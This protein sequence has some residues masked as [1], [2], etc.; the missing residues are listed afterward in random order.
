MP[1]EREFFSEVRIHGYTLA[2]LRQAPASIRDRYLL[3]EF[4]EYVQIKKGLLNPYYAHYPLVEPRELI[5][6][7]EKNFS[8]Y[9]D[10]PS[11]SLV[12]FNRPLS[13]QDEIFQF[14][15]LHYPGET[16]ISR[17]RPDRTN[18]DKVL[19]HL[20]RDLRPMFRQ[21]FAFRDLTDLANY[22]EHLDF[23]LHMDRAHI[24]AKDSQGLFR[25]LGVYASFPS[26]LDTELK[27]LGHRLGKF[28]KLDS[29]TYEREREF[30]YQFLMELYGFPIAAE[31]RTSAALFARKLSRLKEQYLIK[32]LGCSDRTITSLSGLEQKKY[33]LVEKTALIAVPPSLAEANPHLRDQ[34]YYV[35][36]N[37]RVV[38]FK[39]TYLQHKYNRFNV[40]EDRALSV[41]KQ[42]I[43]HPY[44]GGRDT[45]LNILKDTKRFLKDL[46]DIVRGEYL[47]SIS[48]KRA[49]LITST[50]THEDRLKFLSAWLAKNQRR[51]GTLS[52]ETFEG[53]KKV[54][55]SYLLNREYKEAFAKH[56]ELHR[57]V[58]QKVAY[59]TQAQ[60]LQTLEKLAQED[61]VRGIGAAQRLGQAL[62]FLEEKQ[63]DL[64]YFYPDLL[65]KCLKLYNQILASPSLKK[66][67]AGEVS[68]ETPFQRRLYEMVNRGRELTAHLE[69][70]HRRIHTAAD[71]GVPFPVLPLGRRP[72]PPRP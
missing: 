55:N 49:D 57:E 61:E 43:L 11:F 27:N 59:L 5:P 53:V 64:P 54:L 3:K 60:Q 44:H 35:D 71:R 17:R 19:P 30:V 29:A 4:L 34:G 68:P 31:R 26:D 18:L 39:V 63:S 58:V 67:A 28:K 15:L 66:L 46:T 12:A 21:S 51:V 62:A 14:D 40:L 56:A 23:I 32:V 45:S 38:I 41:V 50:K 1:E 8:E 6:S 47:G 33:P 20:D 42:E 48:Y 2:S 24:V 36:P 52:A 13:Y 69:E 22:E 65:D 25:L 9:K 10:L 72:G 37:R 70:Q 7:F 16:H